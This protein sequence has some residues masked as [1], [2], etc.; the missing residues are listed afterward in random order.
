MSS[1]F[2]NELRTGGDV[3]RVGGGNG[4]VVHLRVQAAELWDTIRVDAP[5]AASV[6]AV[7]RAALQEFYPAGESPD[8]FVTKFR[9]FEILDEDQSLE[10]SGIR[11]GSTLLLSRRRRRPVR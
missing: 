4:V 11:D 7:K 3:V 10:D 6:G 8:E 2:V 5:S 1:P 9:G